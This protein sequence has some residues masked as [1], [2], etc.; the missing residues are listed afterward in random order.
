MAG[1]LNN[2]FYTTNSGNGWWTTKELSLFNDE[3]HPNTSS[4]TISTGRFAT[5]E[6]SYANGA[7]IEAATTGSGTFDTLVDINLGVPFIVITG[8]N[9]DI[10][11]L[12]SLIVHTD[13]T[14]GDKLELKIEVD[15]IVVFQADAVGEG[16]GGAIQ[17]IYPN[18][19][20]AYGSYA[21]NDVRNAIRCNSRFKILLARTGT[22][23]GTSSLS[24]P[25]FTT[26]KV[27]L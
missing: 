6:V 24:I 27:N 26:E 4:V 1:N 5:D 13:E 25:K 16:G 9:A 2:G 14:I 7:A 15:G 8:H 23:D 20:E 22:F 3:T 21:N 11:H 18:C 19:A 17:Q 10:A 12:L